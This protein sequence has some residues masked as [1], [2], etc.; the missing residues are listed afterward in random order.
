MSPSPLEEQQV[1]LTT[2]SPPQ[3]VCYVIYNTYKLEHDTEAVTPTLDKVSMSHC[4]P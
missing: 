4:D 1:C 3:L 2:E